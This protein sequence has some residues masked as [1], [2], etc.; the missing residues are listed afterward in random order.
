MCNALA[1]IGVQI[2]AGVP[3][4]PTHT[5]EPEPHPPPPQNA[6]PRIPVPRCLRTPVRCAICRMP[7]G[8]WSL[9]PK[10]YSV[11]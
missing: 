3:A 4:G 2:R 5:T 10:L 8:Y 1:G 6:R 7:P 11:T 9:Q